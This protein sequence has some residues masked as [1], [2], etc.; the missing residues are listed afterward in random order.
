MKFPFRVFIAL[1]IITSVLLAQTASEAAPAKPSRK[2]TAAPISAEQAK[3]LLEALTAQQQ[4]I[5]Q[6]RSEVQ[7]LRQVQQQAA[8]AQ[9]AAAEA[10]AKA[11]AAAS[12]SSQYSQVVSA[13]QASV[14]DL[15]TTDSAAVTRLQEETKKVAAGEEHPDTIRFRNV[16]ITPGGYVE[17]ATVFRSHNENAD[18]GS[19]LNNVPLAGTANSRLSEF[20]PSAR[21]TRLA[22]LVET[23]FPNFKGSGYVEVDFQGAAPTANQVQTS[24]FNLRQRQLWAQLEFDNGISFLAG[25]SWS[26]LT[27]SRKGL[28]P[29]QELVPTVIDS[30]Y[31]AGFN[32]A[33]HLGFRVTKNFGNKVWAAFAVENPQTGV[34]FNKK[35]IDLANPAT[36]VSGFSVSPNALSPSSAYVVNCCTQVAGEPSIANG[37][38]TERAPD[39]IAKVV[40]EPG[41]GH[42]EIKA[43]GRFLRDRINN[44]AFFANPKTDHKMSGAIGAAA[45]L[46]LTKKLDWQGSALGGTA[47]GRYAAGAGSDVT[48]RPD[49]T[50]VPI[51]EYNAFT[52]LEFHPT[53]KWDLYV[54]AGGEYYGR[55]AYDYTVANGGQMTPL[56]PVTSK[57]LHGIANAKTFNGGGYGSLFVD[58]SGCSF[59]VAPATLTVPAGCQAVSRSLYEGQ[60][61]F[62]YRLHKGREGTIQIGASYAYV[63]RRTWRDYNGFA[64]KGI[65][66]M[67]YTSF[68]YALP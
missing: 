66:N 18:V 17:A 57:T 38:S 68:R 44:P 48:V 22:T 11:D 45:V 33:R 2:K 53:P 20:R 30:Q 10:Q 46:P 32:Y 25:Q 6:L 40:F 61:G 52:G 47:I 5:E 39:L 54:Y 14:S 12:A 1:I 31:N 27:T 4:Q 56:A 24:G 63:I 42:Y 9:R 15:K 60:P 19:V 67:V 26:L 59:E 16:R 21:G 41:F 64:P 43:V 29:R 8:E 58:N 62:W 3:A 7:S 50:V 65:E 49:G 35:S 34:S 36:G 23:N 51:H 28:A 55:A 37:V 13:L